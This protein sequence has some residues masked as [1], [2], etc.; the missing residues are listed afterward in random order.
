MYDPDG[1]RILDD[2]ELHSSTAKRL[3][4][5]QRRLAQLN[6]KLIWIAVP[7]WILVALAAYHFGPR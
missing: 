3:Q 7:L 1:V 6:R 4:D 2:D 5:I